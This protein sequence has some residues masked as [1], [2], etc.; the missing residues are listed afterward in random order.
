MRKK[1]YL[2][3]NQKDECV[4]KKMVP[5]CLQEEELLSAKVQGFPVPLKERKASE[6]ERE[7]EGEGEGERGR[8]RQTETDRERQT[9]TERQRERYVTKFI[10]ENI[11]N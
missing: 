6:R 11:W 3:E 10:G 9:E 2:K 1:I 8:E 5:L 7:G 4:G